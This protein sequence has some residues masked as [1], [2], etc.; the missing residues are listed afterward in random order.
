M[1]TNLSK[2]VLL[3]ILSSVFAVA[4]GTE[5]KTVVEPRFDGKADAFSEVNYRGQ[6][7]YEGEVFG[8]FVNDFQ[9]DGWTFEASAG[10]V[11]TIETTQRGT[12][13]ALD[14]TLFL[15]GPADDQGLFNDARIAHDDDSGWGEHAS[16]N[17]ITL[18][19]EGA[20][21]LV[22]GT[23]GGD[24]RGRYRLVLS[25][26]GDGCLPD[27]PVVDGCPGD[28]LS[29]FDMCMESRIYDDGEARDLALENCT[30]DLVDRYGD[31]CGYEPV[32]PEWC[33]LS[34]ET[35][36]SEI[37]P[38][39]VAVIEE[40]FPPDEPL[41][42][43]P[44]GSQIYNL[45]HDA[46]D[47]YLSYDDDGY[48]CDIRDFVLDGSEEH[49]NDNSAVVGLTA[50]STVEGPVNYCAAYT[51]YECATEIVVHEGA[52]VATDSDCEDVGGY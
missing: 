46:I 41:L 4:C 16:L 13:A 45:T 20:Y 19:E 32:P 24:G 22:V 48:D 12:A 9:F 23:P 42:D 31:Q 6:L 40:A 51:T 17:S 39:C 25:C 7:E 44:S 11:V 27:P 35:F 47:S 26:M 34:F 29:A 3:I 10:A 18:G 1:K 15:Y 50:F 52:W 5:T 33:G 2:M 21:L 49:V 30:G 8:E 28:L 37:V 14:N 43:P 38:L 36:G